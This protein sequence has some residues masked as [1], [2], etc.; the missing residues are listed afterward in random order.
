MIVVFKCLNLVDK[1]KYMAREEQIKLM[2]ETLAKQRSSFVAVT[3]RRRVGKTFLIHGIYQKNMC[4]V[5]T[6][7][8]NAT[9]QVQIKNFAQKISEYSGKAPDQKLRDWQ[10]VFL[11]LKQY[12]KS[13][14][15]N[16]KQVIFLDELPWMST[17]KSGFIQLLAH[18]WN[19]Y[20][21]HEKHFILVICGSATSWITQ[22]I[23]NDKGGFHNRITELI[24]LQPFTL[25]ETKS[26]LR[27]KKILL[28]DI[29]IVQLYMAMGGIPYYIENIK[30][31]ESPAAAIER[32]CFSASG[33]LKNE[34][35]NLYSALF[36]QPEHY[37][38]IVATLA[39]AKSGLSREEILKKSKVEGG[40]PYT[41][42]MNDL[43]VSGFVIEEKP[44]GKLKRGS[45]YKLVD[46]YSVFYHKF[47]KRNKKPQKGIWQVL[48][49]SQ[50]YK[51][52]TGYAFE[53]LC[54]KH[55]E[56]IKK[57]LGIASVYT[58]SSS[59]R[60]AAKSG[61][62]GFQIDLLLD[63]K[64]QVI[65]LCECKFF[66]APFEINKTYSVQLQA[67]KAL[68]K[69]VTGTKKSVFTTLITN[70]KHTSNSHFIDSI[71]AVVSITDFM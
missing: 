16:K 12:L 68:F 54:Y 28:S 1:Y 69:Q 5:V 60:Q 30:R 36:D 14:P 35:E 62:P 27:E 65:N 29:A 47:I 32:M 7:I 37:E 45:I 23:I 64:D 56:E 51:I 18:L 59:F 26:F 19:D 57:S 6:G 10:E 24:Q 44:F 71:D 15:K 38:A 58:E 39:E 46:E 13:L 20:L 55:V 40:G 61:R 50:Q 3:G 22:K 63:R 70:Q 21:S 4:L 49:A 8:Q 67:R 11:F 34:Y 52:W 33:L 42:V 48:S 17:N 53:T 41:R 9:A 43:I 66:D 2:T 25:A 31:G